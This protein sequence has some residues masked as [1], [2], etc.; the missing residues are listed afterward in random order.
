MFL[1]NYHQSANQR[2]Q[3]QSNLIIL[4][5]NLLVRCKKCLTVLEVLVGDAELK[6]KPLRITLKLKK[7][8]PKNLYKRNVKHML[9]V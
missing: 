9:K 8:K 2:T 1:L 3:I 4:P 6:G 7:Q 5:K